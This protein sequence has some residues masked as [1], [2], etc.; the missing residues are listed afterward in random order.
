[1]EVEETPMSKN[2]PFNPDRLTCFWAPSDING[3][4]NGTSSSAMYSA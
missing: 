4:A 1:M 3:Y 2:P